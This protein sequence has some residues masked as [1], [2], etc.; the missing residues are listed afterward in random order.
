[1][2]TPHRVPARQNERAELFLQRAHIE[3]PHLQFVAAGD[4]PRAFVV[5]SKEPRAGVRGRIIWRRQQEAAQLGED[6]SQ[7]S[8]EFV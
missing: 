3:I 6:V 1:M 4:E 5:K 7:I 8:M 2:R